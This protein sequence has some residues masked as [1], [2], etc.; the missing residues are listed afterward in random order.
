M[1]GDDWIRQF[2]EILGVDPP[3]SEVVDQLLSI[4]GI[5]AHASERTAAPIACYLIGRAGS[6]A[7]EALTAA[8][9]VA[10]PSKA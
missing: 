3:T 10:G 1:T 8:E 6:T 7:D 5:A 9:R 4:A 2:A